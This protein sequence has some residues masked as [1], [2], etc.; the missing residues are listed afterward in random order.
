MSKLLTVVV[1]IIFEK[2]D[3]EETFQMS[4]PEIAR[5]RSLL[6]ERYEKLSDDSYY[7]ERY[8]CTI[9]F[10]VSNPEDSD[11]EEVIDTISSE[12][13]SNNWRY[14]YDQEEENEP[15]RP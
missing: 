8:D 7:N 1:R 12:L 9:E 2:R 5:L 3:W 4:E 15:T 10:T 11:A 13:K 6:S 14:S